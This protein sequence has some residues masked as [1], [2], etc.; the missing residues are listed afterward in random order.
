M[1]FPKPAL[2]H[3]EPPIYISLLCRQIFIENSQRTLNTVVN[4]ALFAI[5]F[6]ARWKLWYGDL[7]NV[8]YLIPL[9]RLSIN[10]P[11]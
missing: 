9:D 7:G 6:G 1:D 2:I 5:A 3:K 11:R 10:I 4:K 8:R